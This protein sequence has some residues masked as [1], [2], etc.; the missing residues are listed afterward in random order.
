MH[1]ALNSKGATVQGKVPPP[2]SPNHPWPKMNGEARD[3][4]DRAIKSHC[5]QDIAVHRLGE[6]RVLLL[7]SG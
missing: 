3:S 7:I 6:V 5:R 1:H 2:F 4:R